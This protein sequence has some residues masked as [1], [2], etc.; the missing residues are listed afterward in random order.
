MWRNFALSAAPTTKRP[1]RHVF[2]VPSPT[3]R[4]GIVAVDDPID[5]QKLRCLSIFALNEV[6]IK[7][8]ILTRKGED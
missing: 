8:K 1:L 5:R 6:Y 7:T 2:T 3:F 4:G